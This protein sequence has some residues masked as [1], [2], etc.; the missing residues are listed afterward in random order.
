LCARA[1][2]LEPFNVLR[3]PWWRP[4][5]LH[6]LFGAGATLVKLAGRTEPSAKI[7]EIVRAYS[8]GRFTGDI[9]SLVEKSGLTNPVWEEMS[10]RA[11]PA[12]RLRA[13]NGALDG[14]IR[15]WVE[16]RAPCIRNQFGCGSC[17]W[18]SQ[19]MHAVTLPDNRAQ[20]LEDIAELLAM[21]A[22]G[23]LV[24]R[25]EMREAA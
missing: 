4:E 19:F 12:C 13:D 2:L 23:D 3:A 18:C 16:G 11:L 1:K 15:P 5:D 9:W 7:K 24:R 6:Y 17:Q 21:C 25:S 10:G 8:T 14:F 22:K 20:R